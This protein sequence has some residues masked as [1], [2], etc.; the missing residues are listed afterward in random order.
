MKKVALVIDNSSGMPQEDIDKLNVAKVI[1]ISFMVNGEEYYEN[2]NMTY[3]Q[4]FEFLQ[5]KNCNV[6]TSQPSI[7]TVKEGWRE[8]LKDYD[9]LVYLLLSS[10]LSEACNAA[11]LASQ[12]EEFS[13]K[14]F[15]VDNGG[16]SLLNKVPMFV[17]RYLINQG[18]S[19]GEIKEY[20]ESVKK[21]ADAYIAVDTLKYLKKG[22]RI[23]PAAAAVG[24]LLSI[25]PILRVAGG[26]GKLDAAAKV[27]SFKLAKSKIITLLK[28][29]IEEN[30]AEE[31]KNGEVIISVAHTMPN[32]DSAELKEFIATVKQEFPDA[33]FFSEDPLPLFVTCHTGPGALAA[34]FVVDKT[35][36]IA[37]YLK[38]N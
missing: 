20:L 13:G 25:K 3:S 6:S 17:A 23:T 4:F 32:L 14:V 27:I 18:K 2:V 26:G 11:L 38:N 30:Y 16:V 31:Y 1:P 37:E 28:K 9:E 21:D 24:T 5:D 33:P 22:G 34:G 15:V 8:V 12:D 35:G 19:A 29:Q 10:G 36:A 7:E